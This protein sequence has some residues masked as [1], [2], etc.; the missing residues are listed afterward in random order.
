MVSVFS[1]SWKKKR[2]LAAAEEELKLSQHIMVTELPTRWGSRQKM[3]LRKLEQEKAIAQVF[4]ADKKTRHLFPKW[5]DIDLES[6][7]KTLNPRDFT[8]ALSGEECVY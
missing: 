4:S 1:F 6:L 3:V 5:Q 7:H 2:D 8:D